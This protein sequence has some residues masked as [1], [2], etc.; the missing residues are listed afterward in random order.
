MTFRTRLLITAAI[1]FNNI[2]IAA[3]L[4]DRAFPNSNC[5]GNSAA[6]SHV[7]TY[8]AII[9]LGASESPRGVFDVDSLTLQQWQR[10]QEISSEPWIARD[11]FLVSSLP[12]R[13]AGPGPR[14][15]IIVCDRPFTNVPRRLCGIAAPPCHAVG[16]SDGTRDLISVAE[17]EALDRSTLVPLDEVLARPKPYQPARGDCH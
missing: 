3:V 17:F 16:Y 11:Q 12:F 9:R 10:L 8:L 15:V 2:G 13:E 1:V 7:G 14:R 4:F 6:L 5:G